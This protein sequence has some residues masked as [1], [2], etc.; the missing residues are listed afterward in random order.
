MSKPTG[1]ARR[2]LSSVA[3]TLFPGSRYPDPRVTHPSAKTGA[4]EL[5]IKMHSLIS[6]SNFQETEYWNTDF[7]GTKEELMTKSYY[8]EPYIDPDI[9][10]LEEAPTSVNEKTQ[11]QQ[12]GTSASGGATDILPISTDPSNATGPPRSRFEGE[13]LV[14]TQYHNPHLDYH[15]PWPRFPLTLAARSVGA[16]RH[17][18]FPRS[19]LSFD[20]FD[21]ANS[22]I[23]TDPEVEEDWVLKV[24]S[25][26]IIPGT[27]RSVFDV[28][29][30]SYFEGLQD[31]GERWKLDRVKWVGHGSS[32]GRDNV[33][34]CWY[35]PSESDWVF[36]RME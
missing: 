20:V 22:R 10:I 33:V 17:H 5:V 26:V 16:D 13:P 27:L 18:M 15:D 36:K 12:A 19:A 4:D 11:S 32:M 3:D 35:S 14:P 6:L 28:K 30:A 7:K 9:E 21:M 8:T 34:G 1:R 23:P 29:E 31:A 2:A 25:N 24:K